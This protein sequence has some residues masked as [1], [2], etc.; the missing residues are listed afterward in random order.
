[1]EILS[2]IWIQ[3]GKQIAN[4]TGR[5]LCWSMH[6]QTDFKGWPNNNLIGNSFW[7]GV[8]VSVWPV[9]QWMFSIQVKWN[10]KNQYGKL[11][12]W[13]SANR[14]NFECRR[15]Y[16]MPIWFECY[17]D[18]LLTGLDSIPSLTHS[19]L[20]E[21]IFALVMASL[22][23]WLYPSSHPFIHFTLKYLLYLAHQQ[24]NKHPINIRILYLLF[25][26]ALRFVNMK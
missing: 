25:N 16:R 22:L 20:F 13:H 26:V 2:L 7:C 12:I 17:F 11:F 4:G 1:M 8:P 10:K 24:T 15:R 6:Q 9:Q 5:K 18:E 3:T 19:S 21:F 23:F 14:L